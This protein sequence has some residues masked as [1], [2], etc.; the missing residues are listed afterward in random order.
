MSKSILMT[1]ANGAFGALAVQAALAAGH[2]VAATMR[3]PEGRNRDAAALL[4]ASG[5]TVVAIDVT[6]DASVASGTTQA[7]DALAG[8]DVLVNVAGTGSYGLTE[9]Y[10]SEQL[11]GLFDI[12]VVGVH[13]MMRAAL[14]TLRQQ[15]RGLV[16]NVSSL[17]GRVSMPFYGPYS[18]AKWAV[19][20]LSATY[21]AELSQF[22]VD[23]VLVEP[24]GFATS[25]IGNLVVPADETALAG[26]GAFAALPDQALTGYRQFLASK[27]EQDPGKVAEAIIQL[28][29]AA[30]GSRPARTIVDFVGM[31]E[32]VQAMN[33]QLHAVT[34][35][36]YAA[37]GSEALLELKV[38]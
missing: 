35:N 10:T 14:P 30:P 17:L 19:E 6:D 31:A 37:F 9:A 3:D 33:E 8:L 27:P 11:L 32:P 24:G 21:R 36:L 13:R 5:A 28:I 4:R 25:W 2:R 22:G 23:V 1:G 12:N 34:R 15:G 7:I 29:E 38:G 26:Y 16:I 18:A 20:T